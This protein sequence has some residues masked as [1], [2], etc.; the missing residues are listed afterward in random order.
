M[1]ED[2]DGRRLP[3]GGG[4]LPHMALLA[5]VSTLMLVTCEVAVR[6]LEDIDVLPRNEPFDNA[7]LRGST[8]LSQHRELR[9]EPNTNHK[10]VNSAG[11]FIRWKSQRA[12]FESW[13]SGTR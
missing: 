12:T 9:W 7:A 3:L 10:L 13:R 8:R 11:V 6:L 1:T 4:L 2:E 5:V